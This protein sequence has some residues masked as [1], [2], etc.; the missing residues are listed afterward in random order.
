MIYLGISI[1]LHLHVY[2]SVSDSMYSVLR[3][4]CTIPNQSILITTHSITIASQLSQLP[5]WSG[6]SC[7]FAVRCTWIN[8]TYFCLCLWLFLFFSF[9]FVS[10]RNKAGVCM[11]YNGTMVCAHVWMCVRRSRLVGQQYN[12]AIIYY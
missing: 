11:E 6:Y 1:H 8:I 2:T 12:N 7:T 3:Y 5:A 9:F 10:F 4:L